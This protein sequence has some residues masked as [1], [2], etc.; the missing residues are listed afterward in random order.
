MKPQWFNED[1]IPFDG[2]WADDKYWVP[3][4][5]QGKRFN[6]LFEFDDESTIIQ[7][8]IKELKEGEPLEHMLK[9]SS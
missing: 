6:A 5:L 9:I 4:Y 7:Y 1:A 3:I 2:M 8:Q